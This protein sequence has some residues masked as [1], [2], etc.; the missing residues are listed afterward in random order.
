MPG[1]MSFKV[2]GV[3]A[4]RNSLKATR[5]RTAAA[6]RIANQA[7]GAVLLDEVRKNVSLKDHTLQDLAGLDHPYARRH[8]KI[9]ENVL[10]HEGWKVHSHT[11]RLLAAT[12]GR[13]SGDNFQVYFDTNRAPHARYVVLGTRVM[14]PRDPIGQT[15]AQ[16]YVRT[17]MLRTAVRVMGKIYRTGASVRF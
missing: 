14:L 1:K 3:S 10:G 15:A 16:K 2:K 13:M 8:G 7:M 11:G 6:T 12:R 9:R 4:L 17:A 5:A